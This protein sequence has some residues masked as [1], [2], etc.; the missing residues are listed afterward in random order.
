[1]RYILLHDSFD[2]IDSTRVHIE[3]YPDESEWEH[4]P[5]ELLPPREEWELGE[6]IMFESDAK[7]ELYLRQEINYTKFRIVAW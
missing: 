2:L 7:A 6:T 3:T 1:M 5:S 4:L